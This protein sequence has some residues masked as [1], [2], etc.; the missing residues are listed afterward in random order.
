MFGH[1]FHDRAGSEALARAQ[2]AKPAWMIFWIVFMSASP[3]LGATCA[4]ET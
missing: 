1:T 3:V 4:R 2:L